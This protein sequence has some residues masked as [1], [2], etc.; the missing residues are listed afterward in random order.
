MND[1]KILI[2][3]SHGLDE[4][5]AAEVI[6]E[7]RKNGEEIMFSE[8]VGRLIIGR[9]WNNIEQG[10]LNTEFSSEML[11]ISR[12]LNISDRKT[13]EEADYRFNLTMY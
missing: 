9:E 8:K 4:E 12:V 7:L 10:I 6:H 1:S 3:L 11:R 13:Y 2:E 5:K